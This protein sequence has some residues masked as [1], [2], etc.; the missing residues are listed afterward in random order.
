MKKEEKIMETK[1][2]ELINVIDDQNIK[3]VAEVAKDV[4][5][6]ISGVTK[7]EEENDSKGISDIEEIGTSD[8]DLTVEVRQITL[9]MARMWEGKGHTH[10]AMD[11]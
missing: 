4:I 1:E 7:M 3:E 5:K 11:L 9:R 6:K 8:D 2:V 10:E